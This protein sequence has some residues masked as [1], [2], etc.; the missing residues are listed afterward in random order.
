[1]THRFYSQ[2]HEMKCDVMDDVMWFDEELSAELA[3]VAIATEERRT[4]HCS[5]YIDTGLAVTPLIS[6]AADFRPS[7]LLCMH[8]ACIMQHASSHV[9]CYSITPS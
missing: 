3:T 1:V 5:A 4:L 6:Y 2:I 9:P 7:H 8:A